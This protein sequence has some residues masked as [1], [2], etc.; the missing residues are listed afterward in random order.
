MVETMNE[1]QQQDHR[2]MDSSLSHCVGG[3]FKYIKPAPNLRPRF[4]CCQ[5]IK[6]Y[7]SH[8]GFLTYAMYQHRDIF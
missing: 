5:N 8:R 3:G 4:C 6:L 7:I 2:L 1:Q